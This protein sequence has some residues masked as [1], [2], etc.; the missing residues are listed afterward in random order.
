[1]RNLL[2]S[3]R[4][5][6]PVLS[7]DSKLNRRWLSRIRTTCFIIMIS[8]GLGAV[9]SSL[10]LD[11]LY[12]SKLLGTSAIAAALW[13]EQVA[14]FAYHNSFYFRGLNSIIG[15]D[16]EDIEVAT[17]DVAAAVNKNLEDVTLAFCQSQLGSVSLLRAGLPLETLDEFLASERRKIVA[18]SIAL[19]EGEVFSLIGLGK[20]LL[21]HDISFNR[22][23]KEKG[24]TEDTFIATLRW[25]IGTYHQEKRR[26][27]W[28]SK[29]N[30]S[31]TTAVGREWTYG[32]T[33][34][35]N[36]FA[37]DIRTS[38]IFSTLTTDSVFAAEKVGEIEASLAREQSANVLLVGEAGVGKTDLVIEVA[39]RMIL[40][41]S[42]NAI[43][44]KQVIVLDTNRLLA[45]HSQKQQL[46]VALLEMLSEAAEAGNTIIAIE[47]ISTFIKEANS[48]GVFIPELLDEYLASPLIQFIITDTPTAYHNHLATLGTFTRRFAEIQIDSPD[49]IATTRLLQGIAL[50]NEARNNTLFTY[51]AVRSI[52]AAADRYLVEGV[53]PDKAIEL[54]VDVA[55]K[56]KQVNQALIDE[57]FVFAYVS[58]KTGVP[59]GPIKE[60][61]KDLLLNLEDNLHQRI[62]GQAEAVRAI[63]KTMRRARIDIQAA[64]KPIGSFLFLG[65]TGVGKTE[66]A[67]ALANIFFGGEDKMQRLDMSEFSGSDSLEKLI[68][69]N[70]QPGVLSNMLREHPYCVLLLDEFEKANQQVHDVFL[71]ILDEGVFTDGRGSR[72]NARNTIIIA[73]SNAGS[74]LIL[75]TVSQRKSLTH[76]TGEIISHIIQAGTFRPEL[77]NRFDNT[78]IFEPLTAEQ[79][80]EVADLMLDDL[81]ERIKQKG[82]QVRVDSQLLSRMVQAY[83][84]PEFGARPMKRA[85]QDLIEEKVAQKI[86][87]GDIKKG[88]EV[89]LDVT[90]FT[91]SDLEPQT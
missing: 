21:A 66:T 37:R 58:E 9:S 73:T 10:W 7:L 14:I 56:A 70:D 55:T 76:L 31:R 61:E 42:L 65:P 29:D 79:Q 12:F 38:A 69:S 4:L 53:M 34:T 78:I 1:M 75:N 40:G 18:S 90:D 60:A 5:Y 86:I 24:V 30:L 57:D 49:L 41:Q 27:R 23:L 47:N 39:K 77:I 54:L 87:A 28:W 85:L 64:D 80:T 3:T 17:Y 8:S 81:Y 68:G 19:P 52:T 26:V 13:L 62:I 11:S 6:Q 35:L 71:Q 59:A 46:E 89:H 83:Y 48:L 36:K 43:A 63:A 25:V 20:Y 84:T 44:G 51:P 74:Q 72:I 45:V 16:E 22:L 15:L 91:R 67:K 32:T 88:Q 2:D 82:Y 33:Y 50:Q